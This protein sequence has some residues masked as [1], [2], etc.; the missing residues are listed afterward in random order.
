MNIAAMQSMMGLGTQSPISA[1]QKTDTS[2]QS[3]GNVFAGMTMKAEPMGQILNEEIVQVPLE[4]IQQLFAAKTPEEL[5][6]ALQQIPG[7]ENVEFSKEMHTIS[8]KLNL[9]DFATMLSIDPEKLLESLKS[10]LEKTGLVEDEIDE[11][12]SL[13]DVWSLLTVFEDRGMNFY[14]Q[15]FD[16]MEGSSSQNQSINLL[17]LLKATEL[18]APKV[19]MTL[20]MEQ[21]MF[22]FQ[23]MLQ[24]ASEQIQQLTLTATN[25]KQNVLP[26][27]QQQQ[28]LRVVVQAD[29]SSSNADENATQ[30]QPETTSHLTSSPNTAI[31]Q[32]RAE[33]SIPQ[34]DS[35]GSSRSEALMREMQMLFKRS[36]F[37]QVGG[38]TR[39]L[40]KLYPEHLGQIR[41]ELHETNGVLSARIL[42]ST[43]LAKGMLDS[44]MHQL[45]NALAQQNLQVERI[46]VTQSIQ[47]TSKNDREQ[48]FN[49]QFKREQQEESNKDNSQTEEEMTFDEFMIE[50]EV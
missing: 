20:S 3:F 7:Y 8:G 42:A 14:Q 25:G 17:A 23:S 15:L 43:A 38:S 31:T 30:K 13:T 41:I 22:S 35:A 28:N 39:M 48:A 45:R 24:S 4:M 18:I 21:K 34:T 36:N 47:E 19:D 27:M 1:G 26:F 44:Q 11:L 50:L 9:T 2:M 32:T 5:E 33:F 46:D 49:E 12:N 29:T 6:Q 40:I 16:S 37:G 10:V